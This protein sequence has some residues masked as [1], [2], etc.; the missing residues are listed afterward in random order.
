[1]DM[2]SVIGKVA[3]GTATFGLLG[4]PLAWWLAKLFGERF[5]LGWKHEYDKDLEKVRSD[6]SRAEN[7]LGE[8]VATASAG[9]L[10]AQE[11]RIKAVQGLWQEVLAIR[12]F[13]GEFLLIYNILTPEEYHSAFTRPAETLIS[14]MPT[15]EFDRHAMELGDDAEKQRPFLGEALWGYFFIYRAF[16]LRLAWKVVKGRDEGRICRWDEGLDDKEDHV[17]RMLRTVLGDDEV[18]KARSAQTGGP[19]KLMNV[20]EGRI[21]VET[22]RRLSGA[23]AADTTAA[24][25]ESLRKT[26]AQAEMS[27][28]A[29]DA[30]TKGRLTPEAEEPSQKRGGQGTGEAVQ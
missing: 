17:V 9:H 10:A 1:M 2:W 8:L 5:Y 30:M 26:V 18:E 25:L 15:T 28:R 4:T 19:Q 21:L 11:Q 22:D 23:L 7:L 24:Q 3:A 13:T 29:L 20:L 27:G 6:F 12:N 14:T 16:T